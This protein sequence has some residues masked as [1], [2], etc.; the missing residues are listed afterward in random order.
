MQMV[1][2]VITSLA[3]G[4]TVVVGHHIGEGRS[5]LAGD[6]VGAAVV[7]F[8]VLGV[9]MTAA[10]EFFAEDIASLLRVP[11]ESHAK[12]VVYLRICCGGTLII[13]FYNVISAVM[14]GAGDANTPLLFVALP[15]RSTL[16]ATCCS[17]GCSAWMSR[18]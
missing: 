17:R 15:A 6:A 4:I 2:F 8:A 9:V 7:L 5:D 18:A 12:A 16:R 11:A 1:T 3:M 14:R 13:I 10:L